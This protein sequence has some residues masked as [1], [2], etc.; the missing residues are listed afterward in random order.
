VKAT[1]PPGVEQAGPP[2]FRT[3]V[4]RTPAPHPVVLGRGAAAR[5]AAVLAGLEAPL[6]PRPWA[7]VTDEA[8]LALHGAALRAGLAGWPAPAATVLLPRGEEGKTWEAAGS[9]LRRLARAG[10]GRDAAVICLGGGAVGDAG[11]FVAAVFLRGVAHVNV[12]TT[13]LAAVDAA[14]GG[15]TGV[16]LPEGKNLAGAFHQPRAVLVDPDLLATLPPR[17]WR[18]GWAEVIKIGVTSDPELLDLLERAAPDAG[19]AVPPDVLEDAVERACRAKAAVVGADEREADARRILNFGHTVGHAIEAAGGFAR[20]RHGEAVALGMAC[21]LELGVRTRVTPPAFAE[22]VRRLL[23]RYGLPVSGAGYGPED[24]APFLL[25][26]KK[27]QAGEPVVVLTAGAGRP[28]LRRFSPGDPDL[29][30]AIRS[31]A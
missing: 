5:A 23:E 1:P 6:A 27:V 10:L 19:G 9:A 18:S 8:V 24:L 31:V 13:L 16:D 3:V 20:W 15:K 12:P 11:G 25:R 30:A 17:E 28:I 4:V 26:D 2:A 21:V 29:H 7:L 22:R 14:V